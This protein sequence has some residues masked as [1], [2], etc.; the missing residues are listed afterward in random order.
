MERAEPDRKNHISLFFQLNQAKRNATMAALAAKGLQD[1]GQP[2]IL[3]LLGE[4]TED[5]T[6]PTQWELAQ[7]LN[8]SPATVANSLKSL[9]R[10][11]Y[12]A[13]QPDPEDRR[14]NRI[15]ITE[16]G[17]D[18]RARCIDVFDWIDGQIYT[19]FSHEELEQLKQFHL[20]MLHNLQA[21]GG[22]AEPCMPVP[23]FC[24]KGNDK[25]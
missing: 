20:R 1:V 16:K 24:Q 15:S 23:R 13:R 12:V 25:L 4:E 5:G 3:F 17:R 10:M 6:L 14:K 22:S 21:I 8:V 11:G 7:S 19:G 2:R 9:E 18:A